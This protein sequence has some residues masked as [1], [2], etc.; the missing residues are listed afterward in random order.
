MT[1]V[2]S[3]NYYCFRE[4]EDTDHE[5]LVELHNDPLVLHNITNPEPITLESHMKWWNNLNKDKEKR[6]IYCTNSRIIQEKKIGFVKFY[7]I[8]KINNNCLLGADI[9]KS[10]R[11]FGFAKPMWRMML[12]YSFDVLEMNRVSLTVADYNHIARRVYEGVGFS[13]EG[14]AFDSLYRDG[15]YYNQHYMYMTKDMYGTF[16]QN[17]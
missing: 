4:V 7:N 1:Q 10:S 16:L 12:Q 13:Y 9:H 15:K 3:D 17:N 6:F 5:W 11:G 8:D 14:T 2:I